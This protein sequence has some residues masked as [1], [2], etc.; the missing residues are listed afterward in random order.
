MGLI[1]H[2]VLYQYR[3]VVQSPK[4]SR[5]YQHQLIPVI[6]ELLNRSTHGNGDQMAT[7]RQQVVNTLVILI[8]QG[9]LTIASA[10]CGED[11]KEWTLNQLKQNHS[12]IVTIIQETLPSST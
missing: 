1:L 6:L 8:S 4:F 5:F 11:L 9:V 7:F 2:I 12:S 10:Q 3:V